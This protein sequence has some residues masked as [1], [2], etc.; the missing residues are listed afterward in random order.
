MTLSS[1][2]SDTARID[3]RSDTVTLPTEAMYARMASAALGDDALDGDPTTRDLENCAAALLG[4]EA[5]LF[6]P[7]CTMANLLATLVHVPR[8]EQAIFQARSHMY[9]AERGGTALAGI[10]ALG[11]DGPDGT[12]HIDDLAD[13]LDA[14]TSRQR[15][16]MIALETSHN[17]A[18]GTVPSLHHMEQVGAVA[19]ERGIAFHIDGARI[20]NA[21]AYLDVPVATVARS[22][23]TV[24]ICLSKGLGAPMGAILVGSRSFVDVARGWRRTL[25]GQ[26]RQVGIAAAAGLEALAMRHRLGE[27][28]AR[29]ATL[30]D[31]IA[32]AVSTLAVTAP[33]TNIVMIDVSGSGQTPQR[34]VDD[35][36]ARHVLVRPWAGGRL[37][38]VLHRHIDDADVR[39]A[40]AAFAEVAASHLE[41]CP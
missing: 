18:G 37:R 34:W 14:R 10:F 23:D 31:L 4:K 25:G 20:F 17:S 19:A 36:A 8:G 40:A 3:L 38:C 33:Q 35:L 1:S 11:V 9:N 15:T 29:A 28:H 2:L 7:S 30:A 21:A 6:T 24:A 22:A 41:R 16:G 12:M 26:Q 5:G 39:Q 27:D 13:I 32:N